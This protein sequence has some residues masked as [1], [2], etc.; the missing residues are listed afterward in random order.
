[1]DNIEEV[2]ARIKDTPLLEFKEQGE[3]KTELNEEQ[4]KF[5]AQIGANA[6]PTE[7]EVKKKAEEILEK[8]KAGEDF[9]QLAKDNS[10]DESAAMGGD[11]GLFG[12][13][14][15]VEEFEKVAFSDKLRDG[16]IHPE[17]VKTKFGFH[18]I[19]KTGEEGEGE[20]KKIKAS[21]ILFKVLGE[22]EAKQMRERME[23]SKEELRKR[24]LQPDWEDTGLTGKQLDKSQVSFDQQVLGEPQVLLNFNDEGREL[25]KQI[26]ERNVGKPVAIFLD[27]QI[28]SAPVV[29]DVIRDGRAVISGGFSLPEAK[30]LS[31]RLNAGALPVPINLISQ[32]NVE[33]SL[34]ASSLEKSLKA[35]LWGLVAVSVFLIFYY[36]L[37]GLVATLALFIYLVM[38]VAI[39]KLSSVAGVFSITLT[40]SGIAGIILSVGMA[41]DANILIFERIK[42]EIKRGRDLN[43]SIKEGYRR[44]WPSIF[45]GNLSTIITAVVLILFGSGFVQGFATVLVLGIILSMFTAIVITKI[46]L[47]LLTNNWF[48][49][50]KAVFLISEKNKSVKIS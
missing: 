47:N 29:N 24:M 26:T 35:G 40:L 42:E 23:K 19:K 49:K 6:V 44:A 28:I 1:M 15:M 10:E 36:R 43:S 12:K 31:E 2:K 5:I 16:Q 32:Q 27:R 30:K 17:L 4:E 33:A 3:E 9:S 13:G 7:D 20:N 41:V 46:F 45:D 8:A 22:E 14:E 48:N 50:H 34:G 18:I 38:I 39:L 21:H 37:A 25:F 11:L